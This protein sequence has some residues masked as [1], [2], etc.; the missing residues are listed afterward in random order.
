MKSKTLVDTAG[1]PLE[2][3]EP[4]T[5]PYLI[6]FFAYETIGITMTSPYYLPRGLEAYSTPPSSTPGKSSETKASQSKTCST[7]SS[8]SAKRKSTQ[9]LLPM[10][11]DAE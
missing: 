2:V 5:A 9:L 6:E 10:A 11:L 4:Q 1:Q 8:N 7:T 3:P